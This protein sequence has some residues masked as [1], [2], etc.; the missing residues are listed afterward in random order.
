MLQKN[1]ISL[2]RRGSLAIF[3]G[4]CLAIFGGICLA[5]FGGIC[6][7][8]FGGI[9]LAHKPAAPTTQDLHHEA[10]LNLKTSNGALILAYSCK[11]VV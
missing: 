11:Q 4:I 6:L 3:G 7:A 1:T 5:I 10:D 2:K 9:C 8:I